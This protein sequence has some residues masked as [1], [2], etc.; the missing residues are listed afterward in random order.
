MLTAV[1]LLNYTA[2]SNIIYVAVMLQKLC[3]Y[4]AFYRHIYLMY[5]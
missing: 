4:E 1:M 2:H 3:T 5:T